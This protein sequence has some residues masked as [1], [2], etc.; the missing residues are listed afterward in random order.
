[1]LGQGDEPESLLDKSS[2]TLPWC[3]AGRRVILF[4]GVCQLC[5]GW[6]DF[7]MKRDRKELFYFAS[8]QSETGRQVF[9][10]CV[11]RGYPLTSQAEEAG[12]DEFGTLVL[13]DRGRVLLRSAA[14]LYA[15]RKFPWPWP[16]LG[17]GLLVP[18]VI[19][20]FLYDFVA[21]RRYRFF[22]RRSFCRLPTP[23]QSS[24]FL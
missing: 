22:G 7:V 4:D 3:V 15:V 11:Q 6:V 9:E 18:R 8:L 23:E 12:G 2:S 17:L 13:L 16:L 1:M 24:R 5:N 19:R 21:R 20:D 14:F 10:W